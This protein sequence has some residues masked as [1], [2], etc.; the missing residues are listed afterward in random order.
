MRLA[1]KAQSQ[2][3]AT[4]ESLAEIKNPRPVAFVQQANIAHGPQQVNNETTTRPGAGAE[5]QN[6]TN[7][8]LE[9]SG[10]GN[11]LEQGTAGTGFT[12][13][14]SLA[15]M[16]QGDGTEVCRGQGAQ[17]NERGEAWGA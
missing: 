6:Q 14:S 3:R 7:E 11:W 16:G 2:C 5:N 9:G 1:L 8:V 12:G 13:D 4:I 15:T 10:N 17:R